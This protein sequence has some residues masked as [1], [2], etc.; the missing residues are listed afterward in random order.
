MELFPTPPPPGNWSPSDFPEGTTFS[1]YSKTKNSVNRDILVSM[2]GSD[3]VKA[4]QVVFENDWE[5]GTD[6]YPK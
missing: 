1:P 5:T 2:E 4:F 3:I 6:W